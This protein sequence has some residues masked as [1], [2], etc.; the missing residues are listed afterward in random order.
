MDGKSAAAALALGLLYLD[1]DPF[2]GLSTIQR[3]ESALTHLDRA[4]KLAG[5]TAL[6][7]SAAEHR[8]A[9]SKSL[10]RERKRDTREKQR[11]APR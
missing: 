7:N 2:P 4:V 8:E 3:L 6:A 1:A 11:N 5:K 10:A 9:A